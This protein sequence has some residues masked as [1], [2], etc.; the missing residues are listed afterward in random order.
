MASTYPLGNITGVAL[1]SEHYLRRIC[2]LGGT[3]CHA[4]SRPG[5]DPVSVIKTIYIGPELVDCTGG[6]PRTHKCYQYKETFNDSWQVLY[7]QIEGFDEYEEGFIYQLQ[8]EVGQEQGATPTAPNPP[9]EASPVK[10]K[11]VRILSKLPAT[12]PPAEQNSLPASILGRSW[13]LVTL[14][15]SKPDIEN[16]TGAGVTIM[17]AASGSVSGSGGCNSYSG[18]YEVGLNNDLEIEGVV[19]TKKACPGSKMSLE[20]EYFESLERVGSWAQ[21]DPNRLQLKMNDGNTLGYLIVSEPGMPRTGGAA[22]MG[23]ILAL[24]ML[25]LALGL[26]FRLNRVRGQGS[27]V[28]GRH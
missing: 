21:D 20:A 6:G 26:L 11:L 25:V 10:Y 5:G 12:P 18:V 2:N 22:P 27:R 17:F 4:Q 16:T 24:G 19:A 14:Q 15:R 8:V 1:R 7:G 23:M 3:R 28:A 9:S 13:Q